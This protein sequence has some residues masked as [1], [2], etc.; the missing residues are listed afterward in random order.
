M[1]ASIPTC[2]LPPPFRLLLGWLAAKHHCT[3]PHSSLAKYAFHARDQSCC[4]CHALMKVSHDAG[5]NLVSEHAL[6]DTPSAICAFYDDVKSQGPR[7]P[8]LAVAC[9]KLHSSVCLNTHERL[10]CAAKACTLRVPGS[11]SGIRSAALLT[12]P[13]AC[14][15]GLVL[16]D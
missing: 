2:C 14:L 6:L 13:C 5:V 3:V 1:H 15:P 12:Q 8:S 11:V 16:S 10:C 7:I 4:L 9:G